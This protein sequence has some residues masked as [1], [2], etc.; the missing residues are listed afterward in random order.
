MTGHN[1]LAR[2]NNIICPI[3]ASPF[4]SLCDHGYTQ[5]TEHIVAECPR[6]MGIRQ[7]IFS[8][9]LL[10]PPFDGLPIGKVLAFLRQSNLR[11]LAW[12]SK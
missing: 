1:H 6:L 5:D 12:D 4:C 3:E 2:H 9:R 8:Q 7:D 10:T 11:A